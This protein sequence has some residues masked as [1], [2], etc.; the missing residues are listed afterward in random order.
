MEI[1]ALRN[2]MKMLT[3]RQ[4]DIVRELLSAAPN[5]EIAFRLGL[6]EGTVKCYLNALGNKLN[7]PNRVGIALWAERSGLFQ[8]PSN[9][10]A[11][12]EGP[13]RN[14]GPL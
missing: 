12:T 8:N 5:K 1:T 13:D 10:H 3:P 11:K 2:I 9:F 4:T 14:T 6:T 7:I